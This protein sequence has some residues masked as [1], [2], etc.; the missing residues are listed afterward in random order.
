MS[1]DDLDHANRQL[2]TLQH[3]ALHRRTITVTCSACQRIYRYDA[4]ALWWMFERKRWDDRLPGALRRLFCGGCRTKT[5]KKVRP[6]FAITRDKPDLG[7]STYPDDRT[8]K[9]I[10]SRYRS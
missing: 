7:Q 1:D 6:R 8:W 5:G 4:V 10:V 2:R 3:C 9:Q